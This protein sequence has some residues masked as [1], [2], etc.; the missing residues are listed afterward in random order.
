M[1]RIVLGLLL[2]LVAVTGVQL[3]STVAAQ[4]A[5]CSGTACTNQGPVSTGCSSTTVT[6][7]QKV[8][9]TSGWGNMTAH[10]MFSTECQAFWV[11]GERLFCCGSAGPGSSGAD[12]EVR[13]EKRKVSDNSLVY[14][15]VAEI[16]SRSGGINETAWNWTNM[17]GRTSGYKVRACVRRLEPLNSWTC[18]SYWV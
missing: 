3:S 17:A 18:T 6:T 4:A 14:K 5:S 2:A 10:L 15:N 13:V 7:L 1:K 12:Y 9:Q 16:P 8:T 11:R